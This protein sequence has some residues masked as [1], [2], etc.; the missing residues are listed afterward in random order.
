[1]APMQ[2]KVEKKGSKKEMIMVEAK[3]E[4]KKNEQGVQAAKT[5]RFVRSLHQHL[6]YRREKDEISLQ[7]RLGR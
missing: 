5:A 2:K 3:K 1:M 7:M 4:I 6:I